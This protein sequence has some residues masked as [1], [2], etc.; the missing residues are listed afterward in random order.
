MRGKYLFVIWELGLCSY[1]NI[2]TANASCDSVYFRTI[3][4]Y[5]ERTG[6]RALSSAGPFPSE[7]PLKPKSGT[8]PL[9]QDCP[10]PVH[11]GRP[12]VWGHLLKGNKD[13]IQ[14]GVHGVADESCFFHLIHYCHYHCF[15][16]GKHSR[17]QRGHIASKDAFKTTKQPHSHQKRS[18]LLKLYLDTILTCPYVHWGFLFAVIIPPVYTSLESIVY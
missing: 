13:N 6:L 16:K 4:P 1:V 12:E 7:P 9:R 3:I 15:W 18:R 17:K 11:G 2:I 10:T 8:T 5:L 14:Y